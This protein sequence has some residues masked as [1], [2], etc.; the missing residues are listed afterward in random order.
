MVDFSVLLLTHDRPALLRQTLRSLSLQTYRKFTVY[1]VDNGSSPAVDPKSVPGDLKVVHLRHEANR[2]GCDV[3]N[4]ALERAH[5]T[6]VVFLADDDVWN[7]GAL[8]RVAEVFDSSPEVELLGVGFTEFDHQRCAP[9][10]DAATTKAFDGA[11]HRLDAHAAGIAYGSGW[12]IGERVSYPLPRLAHSSASFYSR[13]LVERTLVRQRQLFVKPFGDAGLVGMC[14][15]T[16]FCHYLDLPLAVIGKA[17]VRERNGSLAN[18]RSRWEREVRFLER[19][20]VRGCSFVN[21]RVE[22]HLKVFAAHDILAE[23]DCTLRPD[24][25]LRHIEQIASDDPWTPATHRDLQEAIPLAVESVMRWEDR[26]EAAARAEISSQL[27]EHVERL[28]RRAQPLPPL[29]AAA[30]EPRFAD[31]VEYAAWQERTLV[32]PR[33]CPPRKPAGL[34]AALTAIQDGLERGELER[35]SALVSAHEASFGKHPDF[36]TAKAEWL[37]RSGRAAD[38]VQLLERV[39]AEHPVHAGAVNDLVVIHW[40][41]GRRE[42]ALRHLATSLK[43]RPLH[44]DAVRNSVA[45]LPALGKVEDAKVIC[46]SYLDDHPGEVE[47]R[48]WLD[49]L[50]GTQGR[51][52]EGARDAM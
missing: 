50:D 22:A 34:A 49:R 14:F 24:F 39:L 3:L 16:P 21:M 44:R 8:E 29:V 51:S 23:R 15:H 36:E 30:G 25:F 1:L 19:S 17:E 52:R 11:L 12:G 6:H 27:W 18:Q 7:P 4:E 13:H 46:A 31:A 43:Q 32:A 42:A 35:V 40:E 45:M 20:P 33:L 38:A 9:L 10:A 2:H 37:Y 26:R 48:G 28:R 5:G 41:S 47:V